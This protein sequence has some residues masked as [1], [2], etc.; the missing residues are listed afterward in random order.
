MGR[1]IGID[2]GKARIGLAIESPAFSFALPH[3]TIPNDKDINITI[4][5]LL[6][7]LKNVQEID[8]FIIGLP[9]LLNGK[10]SPLSLEVKE[11]AKGLQE[12]I[13][14]PIIFWDERLTSKQVDKTLI[15]HRVKRKKR[16]S[17]SDSLAAAVILQSYLDSLPK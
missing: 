16:D 15:G 11:F 4:Q 17:L 2:Y 7:A 9:L 14:K 5:K 8:S 1:K 6:E 13:N 12:R 3:T 10:D